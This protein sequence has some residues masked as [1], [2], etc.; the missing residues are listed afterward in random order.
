[1]VSEWIMRISIINL[2]WILF[3]LPVIFIVISIIFADRVL[4]LVIL[5]PI[6]F[7]LLPFVFFP[8]TQAMFQSVRDWVIKDDGKGLMKEYFYYYKENYKKSMLAGIIF[9][10]GWAI[11]FVDL[12]YFTAESTLL[13]FVVGFFGLILF[14]FMINFFSVQAHYD[15]SLRSLFKNTFLITLGS[16]VLSI[17][18]FIVS[19]LIVMMSSQF[20]VMIPFF[21]GAILSFLSFSAF[22]RQY[23]LKY[24]D[25]IKR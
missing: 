10:I 23:Y 18:V 14:V 13:M 7:V 9:T 1:M 5:L 20:I 17:T 22:Y 15:L 8:A 16:P 3:N 12:L 19:A 11:W 25:L 24:D 4:D 2:L 6:L 21:S